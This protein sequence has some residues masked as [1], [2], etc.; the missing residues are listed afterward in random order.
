VMMF[1]PLG[2]YWEMLGHNSILSPV[3]RAKHMKRNTWV[4]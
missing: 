3:L 4:L 1:I 2:G